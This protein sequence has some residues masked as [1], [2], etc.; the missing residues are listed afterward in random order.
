MNITKSKKN[1]IMISF[2]FAF[3]M[4]FALETYAQQPQDQQ[5]LPKPLLHKLR[6][7]QWLQQRLLAK[8]AQAQKTPPPAAKQ[9]CENC[10]EL[11]VKVRKFGSV[12]I[13]VG[14]N[15]PDLPDATRFPHAPKEEKHRMDEA[16]KEAI[17]KAQERL[18]KRMASHKITSIKKFQYTPGMAMKADAG[19]LDSLIANPEVSYIEEDIPDSP[20]LPQSIPLIGADQ[21]WASGFTGAAYTVAILDT[22]VDT[23][24][25]FLS[26]KVVSEACFSTNDSR[27]NPDDGTTYA[28]TTLCPNGQTEDID[29]GAGINC[30]NIAGCDHGTHVAGIAAGK[31]S[32]FS[33]VAKD[34]DIISIQVFSRVDGTICNSYPSPCIRTYRRDQ[35]SALDWVYTR[36]DSHNIV[37]VNMSLGGGA[38]TNFCDNDRRKIPI[39]RLRNIDTATIVASGNNSCSGTGCIDAISAP[40]CISTAISVGAATKSDT[41][42]DYSNSASFLNL[43]APGGDRSS[44]RSKIYSSV[45]GGG[46][47]R[48]VGTSMAAPHVAGAWAVIKQ[49]SPTANVSDVLSILESN[50]VQITDSRNNIAKPRICLD[51]TPWI[52]R[53]SGSV[54]DDFATKIVVDSAGNVYVT[55][56]SC[57]EIDP[58]GTCSAY[59]YATV[60][61]DRNGIRLWAARYNDGVSA[62]ATGLAVDSA[63]NVYVSGDICK[64]V[65]QFGCS[66]FDIVTLK[67]NTNGNILWTAT[68]DAGNW[69]FVADMVMDASENVYLTAF[70]ANLGAGAWSTVKYDNNGNQVWAASL[71]L[72]GNGE[73]TALAV[74]GSGNVYVTGYFCIAVSTTGGC[75]GT[76]AGIVKYSAIGSQ[77]WVASYGSN[78]EGWGAAVA[79]DRAGNVY[80][81]GYTCL[82]QVDGGCA[83]YTISV[84]K[85]DTDGNRLFATAY[86][87]N[88]WGNSIAVDAYGNVYVTGAATYDENNSY[89][90]TTLKYD[91]NGNL[92]WVAR[93]TNRGED[94][95]IRLVLD[96]SGNIYVTGYVCKPDE[97]GNC[98][99]YDY[100]TVKYDNN[101]NQLWSAKYRVG[102]T[103]AWPYYPTL[104][105]DSLQN[106]Y[107]AGSSCTGSG[108]DCTHS[109]GS[110]Y[111]TV[112]YTPKN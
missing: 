3:M 25:P 35:I 39:D 85:Y 46:F 30:S 101:G 50:G 61:Y 14:L 76:S 53:Y 5:R 106:V 69:G 49:Q 41:V 34:A 100:A 65:D 8:K 73:P 17:A 47:G 60:K 2:V 4:F 71:P 20:M 74:D 57:R 97:L 7:P 77:L 64:A 72:I 62:E 36:R 37:A 33:G 6:G 84:V 63:G 45:P 15:I 31:G 111:I 78:I 95:A 24:H 70:S 9:K 38:Y 81:T 91:L 93:Y 87:E 82:I 28:I 75:S 58:Y 1:W 88:A 29:P 103:I 110:D 107:V 26:G 51:G 13:I 59:D 105:V 55:G 102:D 21:A 22:G 56:A 80:G 10:D 99:D 66:H 44:A 27:V 23:G 104:A 83:T 68:Y 67:Y 108:V 32:T 98:M 54:K 96:T 89:D 40:A 90:Y 12:D 92:L 109:T 94:E 48:M 18:L 19:A 11:L 79:V 43:L 42:P 86:G 52:A 16:R 112:K